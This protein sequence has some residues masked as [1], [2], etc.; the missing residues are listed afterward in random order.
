MF[1]NLLNSA[2]S[3]IPH[4]QATL[5]KFKS[6]TSD[7]FAGSVAEYYPPQK[8][9]GSWQSADT[10]AIHEMGLDITKRY[11]Q[12][13]TSTK[14]EDVQRGTMPDQ[15]VYDGKKYTVV[16]EADWYAQ[17]GWKSIICIEERHDT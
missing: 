15:L 7:P 4:Q 9:S 12:F 6:M 5:L 16:G 11:R 8:I 3:V 10:Q 2:L 17:D 1:N 13:Y 14:I